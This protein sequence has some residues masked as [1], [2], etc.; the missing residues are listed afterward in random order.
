MPGELLGVLAPT[1]VCAA[2]GWSWG[3]WG[4]GY[5][6]AL[7]TA[8]ISNIGAP[9]L[10]FSQLTAFEVEAAALLQMAV[11]AGLALL[12]FATAGAIILRV[13]G[14]PAHTYLAPLMF[15]NA[16]NLGLSLCLFAFGRDGLALGICFYAVMATVHFTLGILIWSGRLSLGELLRNPLFGAALLAILVLASE[17]RVPLWIRNTTEVLGGLTIPLML[18][19]L[20]V[21]IGELKVGRLPRT[22]GALALAPGHGRHRG[23]RPRRGTRLR[24]NQQGSADSPVLHARS[25]LQLPLRAALRPLPRTGREHRGGLDAPRLPALSPAA[26]QADLALV[27]ESSAEL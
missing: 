16:G 26:G 22:I 21:S 17:L 1:F 12:S 8:L 7:I 20:G 3:R 19:T 4:P 13:W 10:V 14:L 6:R 18:L 27:Q 15:G 5:D 24:G 23:L 25:G 2:L 9:C 11:G